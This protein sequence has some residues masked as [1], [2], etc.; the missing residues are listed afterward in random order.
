MYRN[1]VNSK[2]KFNIF[3]KL[4]IMKVTILKKYS[5]SYIHKLNFLNKRYILIRDLL[6]KDKN[7]PDDSAT[8]YI[9]LIMSNLLYRD[10][11]YSL[12]YKLIPCY[13][14]CEVVFKFTGHLS[15]SDNIRYNVR[16]PI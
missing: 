3:L 9:V 13:D 5:T 14:I 1:V 16:P 7:M 6:E 4:Y 15:I 8:F 2:L 11:V 10:N 12:L